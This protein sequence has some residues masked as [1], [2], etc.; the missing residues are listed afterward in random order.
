MDF[1]QLYNDAQFPASYTGREAFSKAVKRQDPSIKSKDIY[2]A[3]NK[4]DSYTLH[5][6]TRRP[7]LFRRIYT[8]GIGYLY[9]I[10]LVD[11]STYSSLN[12]GFNW[13]ITGIDTFS[14][15]AWVF[16][17]KNKKGVTITAALQTLL[18]KNR[19]L[20]IE[21]DQ[22]TEFYNTHF[23]GLLRKLKIKWYSTYS[24]R[25]NAIVE[26]FN[27]T[28]KTRMFRAFT[29]R[30]SHKW[31]D[32]VQ[33]LVSGY[34]K[35]KHRSIGFAPDDVNK[36][37]EKVVRK[38][39]FPEKNKKLQKPKFKINDTVRITRK[40]SIFQKGYEQTY[41]YEVFEVD[42][43]KNTYPITY[44]LRDY[45]GEE[46]KGSF[47]ANEIQLV[48]K[49][50]DIWPIERIVTT[51]KRRGITEYLV[52]F[53]GYSNEANTWITQSDLFDL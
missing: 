38:K 20:K 31:I 30:G 52:K 9:Q 22:G 46:I 6:P 8:K 41:S 14:K 28:L 50:D 39:L 11:M 12:D 26:R 27:R 42:E 25:K 7:K 4:I 3:L 40:K 10:D 48:D 34:N 2:S 49:S 5:K 13:L 15:K 33:D 24:E 17:I 35:T 18:R 36:S 47:Y 51:R 1:K 37:N 21:F 16:P 32:I 29:A 44:G 45:K 53:L 19:P 23:L 43:V